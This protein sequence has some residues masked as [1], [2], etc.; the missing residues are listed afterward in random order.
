MSTNQQNRTEIIE[1]YITRKIVSFSLHNQIT[2][3][4]PASSMAQITQ[5]MK[6]RFG[7]RGNLYLVPSKAKE[8]SNPIPQTVKPGFLWMYVLRLN[9]YVDTVFNKGSIFPSSECISNLSRCRAFFTEINTKLVS[10]ISIHLSK[11]TEND[12]WEK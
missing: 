8:A 6:A 5:G 2:T 12:P 4:E 3:I 1:T 9:S 7:T 10:E 11:L